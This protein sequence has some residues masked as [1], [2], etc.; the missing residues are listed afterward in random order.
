MNLQERLGISIPIIQAPMAGV[1]GSALAIAVSNAGGLGSLPT[2]MFGTDAMRAEMRAVRAGTNR[3]FNVNCFLPCATRCGSG[4]RSGLAPQPR[5]VLS[6]IR[7]RSQQ[8]S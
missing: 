3:P 8:Y 5:T 2:A 4:T 7:D 1:Q 6:R